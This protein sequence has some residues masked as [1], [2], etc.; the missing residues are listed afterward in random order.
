V[1]GRQGAALITSVIETLQTG[2][3]AA[4]VMKKPH[5]FFVFA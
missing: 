1:I 5:Y 2:A 4:I 3:P